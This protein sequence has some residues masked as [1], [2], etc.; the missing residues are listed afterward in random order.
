MAERPE[1]PSP[2]GGLFLV[3]LAQLV[4]EIDGMSLSYR[5]VLRCVLMEV[6]RLF[7][8]ISVVSFCFILDLFFFIFLCFC[9]FL[10]LLGQLCSQFPA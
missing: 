5:P 8:S 1:D 4:T 6:T 10:V 7:V 2:P 3:D 9:L